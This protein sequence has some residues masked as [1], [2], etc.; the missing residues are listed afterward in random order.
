MSFFENLGLESAV[1]S[2]ESANIDGGAFP[3]INGGTSALSL[4][5]KAEWKEGFEG[6]ASYIQITFKLTDTSFKDCY[7]RCKIRLNDP[8]MKKRQKAANLFSRFYFLCNIQPPASLP[9]DVD[10]AQFNGQLLGTEISYWLMQHPQTMVWTDGNWIGAIFP[11][12]NFVSADGTIAPSDLAK[13]NAAAVP[14]QAPMAPQAAP[15]Q[16]QQQVAYQQPQAP[17]QSQGQQQAAPIQSQGQ[18]GQQGTW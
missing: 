5:H 7:A 9:T 16:Q 18:Q 13:L 4:I 6:A 12:L 3:L 10:L 2:D 17:M 14:A 1:V 15:M 11:A 8:D